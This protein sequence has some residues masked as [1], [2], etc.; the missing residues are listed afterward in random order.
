MRFLERVNFRQPVRQ[1]ETVIAENKTSSQHCLG[2][3][4]DTGCCAGSFLDCGA[5][6]GRC[7]DQC[8][9][10]PG[11]RRAEAEELAPCTVVRISG[12]IGKGGYH[13]RQRTQLAYA[14]SNVITFLKSGSIGGLDEMFSTASAMVGELITSV[15]TFV[16]AFV[17]ACYI[18]GQ[19]EKLRG[20]TARVVRAFLPKPGAD[21][22]AK[23]YHLC[24]RTFSSF[25]TGQCLEA[26]I[27]FMIYLQSW[28]SGDSP[29]RS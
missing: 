24:S 25:I 18:L 5:P 12:Y 23:L 26:C 22:L 1:K 27:L 8:D 7:G 19:K 21:W 9:F 14:V 20:Q 28:R 16:I 6:A 29:M 15:S 2:Y 10:Q 4:A 3:P 13:F 17:F 11:I